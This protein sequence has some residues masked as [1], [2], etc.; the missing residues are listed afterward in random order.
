[1]QNILARRRDLLC[2]TVAFWTVMGPLDAL[3]QQGNRLRLPIC[4][5]DHKVG[6]W[7]MIATSDSATA[8]P[9]NY[10]RLQQIYRYAVFQFRVIKGASHYLLKFSLQRPAN[11]P[12]FEVT[13]SG[14]ALPQKT[15]KKQSKAFKPRPDGS[16]QELD[17]TDLFPTANNPLL[18]SSAI[19]IKVNHAGEQIID[20]HF[21]SQGFQDAQ[22]FITS[23]ARRLTTMLKQKKCTTDTDF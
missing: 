8:V 5:V 14:S 11:A 12:D 18:I 1:M 16:R 6:N 4:V 3:A 17:L 7:T 21:L 15:V 9:I 19:S 22:S 2:A 13:L 20:M 23:E 10:K